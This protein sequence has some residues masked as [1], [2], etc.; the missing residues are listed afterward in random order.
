M[1]T[2]ALE[3]L[4]LTNAEIKIYLALLELG[5]STAGPILQRTKLQNSVVHMTLHKLVEKGF[6][7][8]VIKGK[9]KHYQA[10][11]PKNILI[12]MDQRKRRFETLLPELIVRQKKQE[13]QEAEVFVGLKAFK[14]MLYGLVQ[15]SRPGDEYVYFAFYTKD[16]KMAEFV[17][18]SI[19][20]PFDEER[21]KRKI[22]VR[23]IAP[24]EIR[25]QFRNRKPDMLFVD[26]PIPTNISIFHDKV[27]FTPFEYEPVA[28][29]I[30]SR[31]LADSLRLFFY[32]IWNKYKNQS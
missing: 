6:V 18:E 14:I 3:D 20:K 2:S 15:D 17:Q 26:F 10:A 24:K 28:F 9:I 30:H 8:Y 21:D 7:S 4:G 23:G 31:Q 12:F 27:L 25:Y 16:E 32:S 19:Y 29:L 1:D 11:D 5:T 22:V 13:K